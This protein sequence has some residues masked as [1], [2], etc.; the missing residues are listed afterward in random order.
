MILTSEKGWPCTLAQNRIAT[1]DCYVNSE[2][3]RVWRIVQ[4][5]LN[6]LLDGKDKKKLGVGRRVLL[7]TP[8]IGKS[9][10]AGSYLLYQLLHYDDKQLH[11]VVYCFGGDLAY[12][13]DRTTITVTKYMDEINISNLMDDLVRQRKLKGFV[14]YDV[15][16]EG[17]EP[18]CG[19]PPSKSWG[20]IVLLS[21][22]EDNYKSWEKQMGGN[23]LVMNRPDEIDVKA[24]CAWEKRGESAE[25]QMKYWTMAKKH[26]DDVGPILRS[27][28]SGRAWKK[29]SIANDEV[30]SINA[31]NAK[32]YMRVE[33]AVDWTETNVSYKLVKIV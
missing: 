5:D 2:V 8:G 16:K 32:Y 4:G 27:I 22:K 30:K 26:M 11:V 18:S 15:D 33:V 10:S 31:L 24:M 25:E 6:Q 1:K 23:Q 19:Y 20:V 17:R 13:F 7:G 12:V 28:F 29:R 14:I 3:E 9:M 21:P